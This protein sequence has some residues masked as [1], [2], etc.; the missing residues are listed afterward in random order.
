MFLVKGLHLL[1]MTASCVHVQHMPGD[2][3][4]HWWYAFKVRDVHYN[5]WYLNWYFKC[6]PYTCMEMELAI[7]LSTDVLVRYVFFT[8]TIHSHIR[9]SFTNISR[10]SVACSSYENILFN[11]SLIWNRLRDLFRY[12]DTSKVKLHW[13]IFSEWSG[14]WWGMDTIKYGK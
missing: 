9:Q 7:N 3:L 1:S 10:S 11:K 4:E 8:I 14:Q 6:W 5:Y 2:I 12:H 13:C